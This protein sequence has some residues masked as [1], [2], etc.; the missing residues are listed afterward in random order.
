MMLVLYRT[1]RDGS[2]R[3]V[4]Y[5]DRQGHLFGYPT[6][7][8]TEGNDLALSRE[9]HFTFE[10]EGQRQ[11]RLRKMVDSRLRRGYQV[12]YSYFRPNRYPQVEETVQRRIRA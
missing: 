3:F 9:R 10:T 1:N 6:L 4:T 5:T 8:V 12:L 2:K 7:T 11:A